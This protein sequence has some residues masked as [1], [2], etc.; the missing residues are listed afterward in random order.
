VMEGASEVM[1]FT[2]TIAF[3]HRT[4]AVRWSALYIF[5]IAIY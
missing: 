2:E 3:I 5:H 4:L 1:Q